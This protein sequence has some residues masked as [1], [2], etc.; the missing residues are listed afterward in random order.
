MQ[1]LQN[2]TLLNYRTNQILSMCQVTEKAFSIWHH[3]EADQFECLN[4]H[5]HHVLALTIACVTSDLIST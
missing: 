1:Y 2:S 5:L 4:T 3:N